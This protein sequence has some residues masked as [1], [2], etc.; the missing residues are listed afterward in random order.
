MQVRAEVT[1]GL[2]TKGTEERRE[3][4]MY[5]MLVVLWFWS[6]PIYTI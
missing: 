6:P 2:F 4:L 3:V 5:E 1:S